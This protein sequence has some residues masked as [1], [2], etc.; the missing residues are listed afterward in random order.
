MELG[1]EP[2]HGVGRMNVGTP[3]VL[4]LSVL[5]SALEVFEGVPPHDLRSVSLSLTDLFIE[6][7][8]ARLP[9]VLELLTPR[10]HEHRGSQVSWRH[11]DAY[12]IVQALIARGVV[13]DFRAPDVAR[14]GFA[15]L[16][17]THTDVYDAVEHLVQVMA[18]KEYLDPEYAVRKAVT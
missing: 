11:E 9:G 15:P 17:L 5:E 14:F 12:G 13:G 6:L 7:V 16:Y 4:A 1:Y 2:A 10:E 3:P 8:E 18:E